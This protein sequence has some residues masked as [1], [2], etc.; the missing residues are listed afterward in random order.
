L[1]RGGLAVSEAL[2]CMCLFANW[3][4][5]SMNVITP[6]AVHHAVALAASAFLCFSTFSRKYSPAR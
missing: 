6:P 4:A 1:G 2:T 3:I 5:I